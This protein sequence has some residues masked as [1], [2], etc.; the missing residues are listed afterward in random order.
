MCFL[1]FASNCRII[2]YPGTCSRSHAYSVRVAEKSLRASINTAVWKLVPSPPEYVPSGTLDDVPG[3]EPDDWQAARQ[4]IAIT[5][6]G[7]TAFIV[8]PCDLTL[9]LSGPPQRLQA[10]GR[11]KI[12]TAPDAR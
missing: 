12:L 11:C 5:A 6:N 8:Y 2:L 7:R 10:R 9:A 4:S 1:S 3:S